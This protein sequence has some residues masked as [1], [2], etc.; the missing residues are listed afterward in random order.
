MELHTPKEFH[1]RI[2]ALLRK[3]EHLLSG[4]LGHTHPTTQRTDLVL[5]AKWVKSEPY[6]AGPKARELEEFEISQLVVGVIEHSNTEWDATVL[7]F[8]PKNDGQ[9]PFCVDYG[10]LNKMTVKDSYPLQ[11]ID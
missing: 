10:K 5:G 11:S 7:L 9:L 4:K 3:H 6:R 1:P 2:R 8:A